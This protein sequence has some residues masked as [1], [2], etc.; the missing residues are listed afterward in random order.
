MER[1]TFTVPE[2]AQLLGISRSAAYEL[3]AAGHIPAVPLGTRRKVVARHV[4]EA[5]IG[6]P[7]PIAP[8][9]R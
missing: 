9:N 4:V 8:S 3:V 6:S 7:I 5:L 1:L 2:V